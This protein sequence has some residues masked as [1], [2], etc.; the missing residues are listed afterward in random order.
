L[1]EETSPMNN[2]DIQL[3]DSYINASYINGLISNFSEKSTIACC[4]P[5]E[6]TL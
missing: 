1:G 6:A 2:E 3:I 5:N 4:A